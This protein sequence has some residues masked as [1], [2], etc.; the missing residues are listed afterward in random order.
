MART[1]SFTWQKQRAAA[2]AIDGDRLAG[3]RLPDE[4]GTTIP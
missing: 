3:E 1:T 2:V 4:V